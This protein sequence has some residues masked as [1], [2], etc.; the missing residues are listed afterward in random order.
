MNSEIILGLAILLVVLLILKI[1][2]SFFKLVFAISLGLLAFLVISGCSGG[3]RI[4]IGRN[5][6]KVEENT[7]VNLM[8]LT[9]KLGGIPSFDK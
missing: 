2:K 5:L 7:L 3:E 9:T 8:Y 6:E 1:S 4:N